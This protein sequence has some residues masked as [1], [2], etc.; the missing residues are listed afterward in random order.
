MRHQRVHQLSKPLMVVCSCSV[1]RAAM[2]GSSGLFMWTAS[3]CTPAEG[4]TLP[5]WHANR[6]VW[7]GV[8]G[9]RLLEIAYRCR[10][11]PHRVPGGVEPEHLRAPGPW[12]RS[13]SYSLW[14]GQAFSPTKPARPSGTAQRTPVTQTPRV[15]CRL[16]LPNWPSEKHGVAHCTLEIARRVGYGG[17][18]WCKTSL[19]L[20]CYLVPSCTTCTSSRMRASKSMHMTT[21][22]FPSCQCTAPCM[23]CRLFTT[24]LTLGMC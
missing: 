22:R 10:Q 19:W 20:H 24:Y 7:V 9:A 14:T 15:W 17:F 18:G 1:R 6:P 16:V 2:G 23:R 11:L 5:G 3:T 8:S 12:H 13:L 4:H 21:P